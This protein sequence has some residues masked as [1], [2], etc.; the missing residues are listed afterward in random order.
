MS[1]YNLSGKRMAVVC[2]LIRFLHSLLESDT[3]FEPF[4]AG[5]FSPITFP[6]VGGSMFYV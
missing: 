3:C 4:S 5:T 2:M 1:H 6:N